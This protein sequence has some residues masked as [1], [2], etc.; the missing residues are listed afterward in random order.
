MNL[1]RQELPGMRSVLGP[2]P[3][4]RL[5]PRREGEAPAEPQLQTGM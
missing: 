5:I 4:G 2:V 1:A 3:E